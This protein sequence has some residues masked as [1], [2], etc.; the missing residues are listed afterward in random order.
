MNSP[1]SFGSLQDQERPPQFR[2]NTTS[3]LLL[4]NMATLR[5]DP[6]T[7]TD[8]NYPTRRSTLQADRSVH[9]FIRMGVVHNQHVGFKDHVA[10]KMNKIPGRDCAA[11]AQSGLIVLDDDLHLAISF[12]VEFWTTC[13]TRVC[14]P[15]LTRF[16]S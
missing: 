3:P 5:A 15:I 10:L 12:D 11:A 6:A 13:E 4:H 7:L 14:L 16:P 9:I 2:P 8:P 1:G